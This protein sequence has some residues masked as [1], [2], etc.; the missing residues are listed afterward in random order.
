MKLRVVSCSAIMVLA[1]TAAP[2]W[3]QEGGSLYKAKCQMCHGDQ[4]QGKPSL[5]PKI[6]GSAKSE[7]AILAFLTNQHA[8]P[9]PG[10]VGCCLR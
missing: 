3:A 1:M 8:E 10:E 9:G 2:V 7:A 5:G 6:A 4:G